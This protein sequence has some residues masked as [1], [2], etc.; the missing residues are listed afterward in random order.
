LKAKELL[1]QVRVA[2]LGYLWSEWLLVEVTVTKW[3]Y[4]LLEM[5]MGGELLVQGMVM[6]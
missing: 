1:V 5:G 2:V 6:K 3:G 4:V